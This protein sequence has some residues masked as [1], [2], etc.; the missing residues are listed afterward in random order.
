[1]P[2]PAEDMT[3]QRH[4]LLTVI[5][6]AGKAKAGGHAE[7]LCRCECGSER[8]VTGSRLKLGQVT[9]CSSCAK[10]FKAA[11]S[12]TAR[13]ADEMK[14]QIVVGQ[15]FGYLEVLA[16]P[17]REGRNTVYRCMCH[18]CGKEVTRRMAHLLAEDVKSCGC[19]RGEFHL[20]PFEPG[21]Q[22]H[23]WMVLRQATEEEVRKRVKRRDARDEKLKIYWLCRC[24][25]GTVKPVSAETLRRGD[26]RSCMW[27]R[28]SRRAVDVDQVG[29][30]RR[31]GNLNRLSDARQDDGAVIRRVLPA[32]NLKGARRYRLKLTR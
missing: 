27:C 7:W 28:L 8:V 17:T 3:G 1:M 15:R 4:G 6:R 13:R 18:G 20:K 29:Q 19:K 12:R 24:Q 16:E 26:S 5:A 25:C 2:R 30:V 31:T 21:T 9:R 22:V 14:S 11:N 23:C 32:Y 10:A